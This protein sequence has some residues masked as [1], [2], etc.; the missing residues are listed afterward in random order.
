MPEPNSTESEVTRLADA[1]HARA[2]VVTHHPTHGVVWATARG[3]R[4]CIGWS[5]GLVELPYENVQPVSLVSARGQFLVGLRSLSSSSPE[6]AVLVDPTTGVHE[7]RARF[8]SFGEL[9][10]V[11]WDGDDVLVEHARRLHRG[12]TDLGFAKSLVQ[13]GSCVYFASRDASSPMRAWT[14]DDTRAP[15][16][17]DAPTVDH[18]ILHAAGDDVFWLSARQ[19]V[20]YRPGLGV[21]TVSTTPG[22]VGRVFY[23]GA[24]VAWVTPVIDGVSELH[25]DDGSRQPVPQGLRLCLPTDEGWVALRPRQSA[26]PAGHAFALL[27]GAMQG[28]DL[29]HWHVA[30]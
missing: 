22:E 20:R 18:G 24:R 29:V 6:R 3:E 19:L 30:R 8:E 27:R 17:L 11:A 28:A 13:A 5:E 14:L 2:T 9:Q 16:V 4:T 25:F 26:H 1:L 23:V 7:E 21:D 12:A 15:S 10:S